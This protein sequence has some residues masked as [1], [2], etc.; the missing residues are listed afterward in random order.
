MTGTGPGGAVRHRGAAF[1]IATAAGWAL[2]GWGIRGAVLHRLDTRPGQLL[3]FFAAGLVAHDVVFAPAVL[4]AGVLVAR[5]APA[6]RRAAVQ[7]ALV[8][9]GV[10]A[11]YAY[12]LVRGYAHVL[13][14]PTSLPRNYATGL[15]VVV[16]AEIAVVT[17]V[18]GLAAFR[19]DRRRR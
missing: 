7:A 3:R 16:A 1:W 14:N 19:S 5:A 13:R 2:M 4:A 12:P 6:R 15:A 18:F 8:V 17:A 11:L 10:T 9:A